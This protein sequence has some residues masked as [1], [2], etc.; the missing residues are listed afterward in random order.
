M[1]YLS[2]CLSGSRTNTLCAFLVGGLTELLSIIGIFCP[3]IELV[4]VSIGQGIQR[5]VVVIARSL[6]P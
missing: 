6:L 3:A 5:L 4:T 1:S 2:V